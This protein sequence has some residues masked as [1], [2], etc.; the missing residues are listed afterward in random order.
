MARHDRGDYRKKSEHSLHTEIWLQVSGTKPKPT[1]EEIQDAYE[2][3]KENH[4]VP[5]GWKLAAINWN[6]SKSGTQGW[7]TGNIRD[8][9]VNMELALQYLEENFRIGRVRKNKAGA[10]EIHIAMEY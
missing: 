9:F 6:H 3:I 8:L 5:S 7:R 4:R 2:Y 1:D 10:W